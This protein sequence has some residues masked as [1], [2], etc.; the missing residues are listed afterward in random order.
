MNFDA[1]RNI[2]LYHYKHS[3]KFKLQIRQNLDH[4]LSNPPFGVLNL[5]KV[6]LTDTKRTTLPYFH[7]CVHVVLH[8]I[9]TIWFDR[10]EYSYILASSWKLHPTYGMACLL[11]LST[12]TLCKSN[13]R[14]AWLE[15]V[16]LI[17][18]SNFDTRMFYICVHKISCYVLKR[19]SHIYKQH[20]LGTHIT[21][22]WNVWNVYDRQRKLDK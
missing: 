13:Q 5:A 18:T 9:F 11:N 15:Y 7:I 4:I 20:N 8:V 21:R 12:V 10:F 19:D 22:P 16:W 1:T 2:E 3:Q 14:C 17:F 6:L